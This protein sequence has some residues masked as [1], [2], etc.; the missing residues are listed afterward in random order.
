MNEKAQTYLPSFSGGTGPSKPASHT[1]HLTYL[2]FTTSF[3]NPSTSCINLYFHLANKTLLNKETSIT[4]KPP[5]SFG[6]QI[7]SHQTHGIFFISSNPP[8]KNS[9]CN[10]LNAFTI[11]K[12]ILKKDNI[13]IGKEVSTDLIR[14][15]LPPNGRHLPFHLD[16]F[17]FTLSR[18]LS[19]LFPWIFTNL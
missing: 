13:Q 1:L 2:D 10:F 7:A 11:F 12:G 15:I 5:F 8:H 18:N 14:Q 17:F 3:H 19:L 6:K 4:L 9:F 16:S